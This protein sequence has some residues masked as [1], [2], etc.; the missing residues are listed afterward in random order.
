MFYENKKP[1]S[2]RLGDILQDFYSVIPIIDNPNSELS[3]QNLSIDISYKYHVL[4]SPCC[5]I[6]D[7][8]LLLSPLLQIDDLFFNIRYFRENHLLFNEEV[9]NYKRYSEK[10]WG[11]LSEKEKERSEM[12]EIK[13]AFYHYFFFE[14]HDKLEKYETRIGKINYYMI[15]FRKIFSIKCCKI[16]AKNGRQIEPPLETKILELTDQ[17]RNILRDK[18]VHFFHRPSLEDTII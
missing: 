14:E 11:K 8:I 6:K 15:D 17:A 1:D 3:K 10:R 7:G 16:Q 2:L 18:I 5:S 4:L 13:Y 9:A 12:K